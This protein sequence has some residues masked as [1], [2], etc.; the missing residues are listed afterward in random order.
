M[1]ITDS[2][3]GFEVKGT[4]IKNFN[5]ALS[6]QTK[7]RKPD[8]VLPLIINKTII[9]SRKVW[10]TFTTVIK[11]P[12]GRINADCILLKVGDINV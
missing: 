8:E 9:Q 1:Y 4:S 10:D 6:K 3:K 5:P 7:L 12:N 2:T 11:E